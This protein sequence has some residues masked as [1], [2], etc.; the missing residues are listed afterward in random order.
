MAQRIGAALVDMDLGSAMT[1]KTRGSRTSLVISSMGRYNDFD[2]THL[3]GIF[4]NADG[5]R[6]ASEGLGYNLSGYYLAQQ[7]YAQTFYI[8]DSVVEL[9]D[10]CVFAAG[11]RA[12]DDV[13]YRAD[14]LN[15]LAAMINVSPDVLTE[16][17]ERYNGF[18]DAG[19]D[20]DFH[21]PLGGCGRI[22]NPPFYAIPNTTMPYATY[23]G[24]M[25]DAN[26]QVLDA[27]GA[28]MPGL[29]AAGMCC[30]S[31]AEQAG[32]FY[33]GGLS[34]ALIFGRLAGQIV[35]RSEA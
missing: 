27:Q 32:I 8:A 3:P 25:V 5:K 15:E 34:Q 30:G 28:P 20:A 31:F 17:V 18:V 13:V 14:T 19:E 22:E 23:G 10:G 12:E 16:E 24:I 9:E 11:K 6:Y 4:V 2:D 35:A 29:Y 7:K 26:C 21:R 33:L 1:L